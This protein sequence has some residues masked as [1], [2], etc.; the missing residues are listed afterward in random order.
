MAPQEGAFRYIEP[1]LVGPEPA[2]GEKAKPK[3]YFYRTDRRSLVN[4]KSNCGIDLRLQAAGFLGA[5]RQPLGRQ[6]VSWLVGRDSFIMRRG[7]GPI[8]DR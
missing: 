1:R 3:R 7:Q 4:N 2:V 5:G 8:F 6:S